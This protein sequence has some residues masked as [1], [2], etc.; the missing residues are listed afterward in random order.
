MLQDCF[1]KCA[2]WTHFWS[3]N[4]PF[5]RHPGI[6]WREDATFFVLASHSSTDR[7]A[8]KDYT[9]T[10]RDGQSHTAFLGLH[11]L[12]AGNVEAILGPYKQVLLRTGLSVDEWIKL[13]L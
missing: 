7:K 13:K 10:M 11:E 12:Q 4:S 9:R 8:H 5:S 1:W 6:F 2:F 3:H